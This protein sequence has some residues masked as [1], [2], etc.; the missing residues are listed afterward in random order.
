[1]GVVEPGLLGTH[2]LERY[3]DDAYHIIGTPRNPEIPLT[4]SANGDPIDPDL[5]IKGHA[6]DLYPPGFF[7]VPTLRNVDKRKGVGF[8][9]AYAHNGWFKSM[10]SIVA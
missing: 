1:M 10:E 3:T 4:F 5:G 8:K 9:K 7:K 2:P 6:G